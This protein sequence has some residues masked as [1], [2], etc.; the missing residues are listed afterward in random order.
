MIISVL[1]PWPLK[2]GQD[3]IL[4][5]ICNKS[6]SLMLHTKTLYEWAEN[7]LYFSF[8]KKYDEAIR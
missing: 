7:S 2:T 1:W 8:R 4:Q 6:K 5:S 3:D